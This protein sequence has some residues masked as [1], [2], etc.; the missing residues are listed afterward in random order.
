MPETAIFYGFEIT[1][2]LEPQ[3]SDNTPTN[4][5]RRAL[6]IETDAVLLHAI[7]NSTAPLLALF[8]ENGLE[9]TP[10]Q[11]IQRLVG[12]TPERFCD[13]TFGAGAKPGLSEA[14]RSTVLAALQKDTGKLAAEVAAIVAEAA[15]KNVRVVL[16]S[17]LPDVR[18]KELLG[19]G[20]KDQ[21]Q[22]LQVTRSH[23]LVYKP[24]MWHAVCARI[25]LPERACVAVAGSGISSRSALAAGM[26]C[27]VA[28]DPA[29]EGNDFGGA[30]YVSAKIDSQLL[31]E[32]FR[33]LRVS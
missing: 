8:K 2:F 26:C 28:C 32:A 33:C 13:Q 31:A 4:T 18:V 24:E 21:V 9:L 29:M 3:M 17:A 14:I 25:K 27:V 1:E 22:V 6:I 12:I 5:T 11:L 10:W 30:D 15:P 20:L 19:E 16:V 23:S 7:S